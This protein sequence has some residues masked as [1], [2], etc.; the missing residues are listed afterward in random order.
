MCRATACDIVG[1]RP[2]RTQPCALCSAGR[3]VAC[4]RSPTWG[5]CCGSGRSK[6]K[7]FSA[8]GARAG[9]S[10]VDACALCS[11]DRGRAVPHVG[12][13]RRLRR[14]KPKGLSARGA[15]AG[16]SAVDAVDRRHVQRGVH[17]A[18]VHAIH[19]RRARSAARVVIAMCFFFA[20]M[21]ILFDA[22]CSAHVHARAHHINS[23][24]RN[25]SV[26]RCATFAIAS[27]K[28]SFDASIVAHVSFPGA[29]NHR[30][31]T[32]TC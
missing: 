12:A 25:R 23:S 22:L 31:T 20:T 2:V 5:T 8:R 27:R 4:A 17:A 15:R 3:A 1:A 13:V 28:R 24:S 30:G 21:S 18:A 14:S 7:G 11:A 19:Q 32:G 9:G 10:A 6:P 29:E 26:A 16:G